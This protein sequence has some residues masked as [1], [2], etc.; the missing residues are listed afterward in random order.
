M[1]AEI[2]F[3]YDYRGADGGYCPA[4]HSG[5]LLL[6][7]L[8]SPLS[9]NCLLFRLRADLICAVKDRCCKDS[10]NNVQRYVERSSR[11]S[12]AARPESVT[13]ERKLVSR[14]EKRSLPDEQID[15]EHSIKKCVA[16]SY[17]DSDMML[18]CKHFCHQ[19][20]LRRSGEMR[21]ARC[22]EEARLVRVYCSNCCIRY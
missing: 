17:L 20:C 1:T 4:V 2:E 13:S 16:C 3:L 7:V 12:E 19:S 15:H 6:G 14:R 18:D 9:K 11:R 22:G 5:S 10:D 21:C 8:S